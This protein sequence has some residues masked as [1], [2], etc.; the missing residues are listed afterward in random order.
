[1]ANKKQKL[2]ER[3]HKKEVRRRFAILAVVSLVLGA[4]SLVM[5]A[6]IYGYNSASTLCAIEHGG[7]SAPQ[8][9]AIMAALPYL[10]TTLALFLLSALLF[11]KSRKRER[12]CV[13]DGN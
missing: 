12:S 3:R 7:A 1:M 5:G 4:I 9:T 2:Q 13:S 10:I 6:Y 8:S 11:Y